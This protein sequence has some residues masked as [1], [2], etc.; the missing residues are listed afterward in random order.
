MN[1]IQ[2][3]IILKNA[4]KCVHEYTDSL[5]W[6]VM[7]PLNYTDYNDYNICVDGVYFN[8][9]EYHSITYDKLMDKYSEGKIVLVNI[10]YHFSHD[11]EKRVHA[12]YNKD[13]VNEFMENII[14]EYKVFNRINILDSLL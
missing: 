1:N 6:Y 13:S 2:K 5:K 9:A 3:Q 8:H 12:L 14:N 10:T 4:N 11:M 7:N